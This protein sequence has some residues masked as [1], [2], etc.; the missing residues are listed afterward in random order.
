MRL[1]LWKPPPKYCST[2]FSRCL[3]RASRT[4][5][6]QTAIRS[7]IFCTY[8]SL[9]IVL[10]SSRICWSSSVRLRCNGVLLRFV[11]LSRNG[12]LRRLCF[13]ESLLQ[14]CLALYF[15]RTV[16]LCWSWD[17]SPDI[18]GIVTFRCRRITAS[19]SSLLRQCTNKTNTKRR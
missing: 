17:G 9:S 7:T 19:A 10:S 4:R 18:V 6:G 8:P 16:F 3:I 5:T 13:R 11:F 1:G 12:K 15:L 2:R 14:S